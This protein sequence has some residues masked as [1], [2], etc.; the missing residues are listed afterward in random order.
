MKK[1]V[2]FVRNY[3]WFAIAL[4]GASLGLG[5]QLAGHTTAAKW[6]L[7]V[8]ATIEAINMTVGMYNDLRDGRY[9]V[10]ILALTAI[11]VSFVMHEYWAGMVI[12][13]MLT[14]GEALEDFAEHR[15]RTELD[16][17]LSRAPQKAHL[18]RGS[19]EVDVVA[20]KVEAG[21]KVVIRP[22]E[23]VPV[24]AKIVEGTASFDESSLTGESI[25]VIKKVGSEI[26]SGSVNM[27]G[28]IVAEALRSAANSQYEQIVKL[29]QAAANSQAP[30]V[31]LADKYAI[32][33]TVI[34]FGIA[35]AAWG[36]S[37]D[38]L[39]F[40]QVLV[41]ATPCP[42]ILAAPI[43]IISGMSR[44]A[45]H[46]IIVK[47]GSALEKLAQAETFAFDKTGTLTE[48]QPKVEKVI[49]Y[50]KF[51]KKD[52]IGYAAALEQSSNHVLAKA[53]VDKAKSLGATLPKTKH[54]T[55]LA[56]HGLE[57]KIGAKQILVGRL[58]ML[59]D[60]QIKVP[61]KFKAEAVQTTASFVAIDGELAGLI[62]FDDKIRPDTKKTIKDLFSQGV[63]SVVM[64]TGDNRHVAK[65]ISKSLGITKVHA[66]M[67]PGDKIRAI[68][69]IEQRP[70]AFIG[71][72]VNDAPALTASDLGIALG[73]R[74]STAASESADIVIMLEGLKHVAEARHIAKRTFFIAQQSILIG[75]GLSIVLMLIFATGKFKPIY[76]AAI[77]ELV[78]IVVIFN[79]LR[80]HGKFSAPKKLK[81]SA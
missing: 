1:L 22:G 74:G 77:Q 58:S 20:S 19:K 75:I 41:V 57:A 35:G 26:M 5:L 56:G 15:A 60:Y 46:G 10:D 33:F 18:L 59:D 32:P 76:G 68:E 70:V 34:S 45:K 71:D 66:E 24:D 51:T 72:G 47:T 7:I 25:P 29:V 65:K 37:G 39:R 52:V 67:L 4:L 27:D 8:T 12:I 17:L 73:A 3:K 16:A 48:G 31:R 21:D 40:L 23:V 28:A 53:I 42:L 30:F 55:E 36:L 69:S 9:G 14:G 80:A 61:A 49:T 62:S 50:S 6:V 64:I 81:V 63:K 54:V 13:L 43:A 44:A 38:S 2:Q 11:V 79:A 78:D